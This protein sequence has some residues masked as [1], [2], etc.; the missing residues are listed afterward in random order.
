[1]GDALIRGTDEYSGITLT[2]DCSTVLVLGD[3]LILG[4]DEYSG[5]T[6]TLESVMVLILGDAL[7]I[8]IDEYSGIVLTLEGETILGGELLVLDRIIFDSL[9]IFEGGVIVVGD[10]NN[11]IFFGGKIIFEED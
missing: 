7:I 9:L 3:A 2:L 6:L 10:R 8:G 1:M 4:T 5:I 11:V